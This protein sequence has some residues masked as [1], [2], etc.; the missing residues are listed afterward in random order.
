MRPNCPI[1]ASSLLVLPGHTMNRNSSPPAP[2]TIAVREMLS[3]WS[4][5]ASPFG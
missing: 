1:T 3:L 4:A 2:F 5:L